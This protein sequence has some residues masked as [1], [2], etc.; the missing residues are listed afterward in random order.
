MPNRILRDTTDSVK[1]NSLSEH[2]ELLFYRL[3]MKADDFGSFHANPKLIKAFCFPLKNYRET[4]ISRWLNELQASGLIAFYDA[5]N[6][7]LLNINNFGQRKRSM[8]KAF[9]QLAD[10]SPQLADNSPP[11]NRKQNTENRKKE[12]EKEKDF[13]ENQ[14]FSVWN[15]Y[16]KSS[17]LDELP[18]NFLADLKQRIYLANYFVPFDQDVLDFWKTWKSANLTGVQFYQN[19]EDVYKHFVNVAKFAKF[20]APDLSA[21]KKQTIANDERLKIYE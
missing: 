2:A 10:N 6:K 12:K 4:D 5:E 16:P 1:I 3:I 8:K 11:E 19:K 13:V 21:P 18:V 14:K 17:D 15:H 7:K 20:K 9:P